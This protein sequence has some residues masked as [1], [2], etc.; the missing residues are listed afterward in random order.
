MLPTDLAARAAK[1]RSSLRTPALGLAVAGA[2]GRVEV[3]V[4]GVRTRGGWE[5]ADPS[6]R[7][8][9]GS[10][11]KPLTAALYALLVQRGGAGWDT[12]LPRLFPDL[13]PGI[14]PGWHD[15]TVADVL[16]C[17]GGLPAD[18]G[19][20]E[21]L[22]AYDDHRP[23]PQQRTD[24]AV[25]AL[26]V[27]PR[28]PGRLVYSNLGYVLVGAAIERAERA[29]YEEVLRARLL[30]P[31]G[32][33]SAGWGPPPGL[34]GHTGRVSRSLVLGRGR[35]ID[36]G[37]PHADN[38]P[39]YGPAGRLHISLAEWARLLRLFMS[40]ADHAI[41]T[42]DSLERLFTVRRGGR[43]WMALGWSPARRI[44]GSFGVQGSNTMWV[45]TAVFDRQRR[46]VV[47]VA[48]NDGRT[49]LLPRTAL[50]AK[51]LLAA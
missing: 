50:L 47:M 6:D 16:A 19:R 29:P 11:L 23:L 41:L 21:L 15:I 32:V 13:A 49:V 31:L 27:A 2:S 18:L 12:P 38:P 46:R 30:E 37:E 8:H 20:R 36:P 5:P 9:I 4:A 1:A 22:A 3:G 26:A 51:R 14:H 10:C 39:L 44:G 45:A 7:W 43:R 17:R 48:A 42:P 33:T 34:R 40:G 25:G 35:A 28:R 24:L